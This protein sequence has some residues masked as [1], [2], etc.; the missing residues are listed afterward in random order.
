MKY[1]LF[2]LILLFGFSGFAQDSIDPENKTKVYLKNGS[3]LIGN[4]ISYSPN[5]SI[6]FEINGNEIIIPLSV[7]KKTVMMTSSN[8]VKVNHL[9]SKHFYNR[10]NFGLITNSNGT[11]ISLTHSVLYQY[12]NWIGVGIGAG[13][14][15]YYFKEGRNVYPVFLEFKSYLVDRNSAPYVSIKSGYGFTFAN[16]DLGQ[17]KTRGG[18]IFNPTFGYRIGS[19][20]VFMDFYF[21]FRF[22]NAYYEIYDGWAQKQQEI[23][24]N[25]VEIGTAVSF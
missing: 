9:K 11:G 1:I 14:D 4:L 20:G 7:I 12:S 23:K 25:R 8:E 10:T 17:T 3:V 19:S 16:E 22:Q 13:I 18:L 5:E 24:W 21:G 6:I 15:N 2:V